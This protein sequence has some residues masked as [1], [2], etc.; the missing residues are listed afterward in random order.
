MQDTQKRGSYKSVNAV[1][2]ILTVV[3]FILRFFV[4]RFGNPDFL[5][6]MI[7]IMIIAARKREDT[8]NLILSI[9]VSAGLLFYFI[10]RH[11]LPHSFLNEKNGDLTLFGQMNIVI[12]V[13][14]LYTGVF[15]LAFRDLVIA[16]KENDENGR[17]LRIIGYILLGLSII[18]ATR[19]L[20]FIFWMAVTNYYP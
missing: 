1:L 5:L 11:C 7:P 3:Y 12:W 14:S 2:R 20:G 17:K 18:P 10:A 4:V 15:L 19:A 9:M 8:T 6:I 13:L 16:S